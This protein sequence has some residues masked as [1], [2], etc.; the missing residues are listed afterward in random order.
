[1]YNSFLRKIVQA[2]LKHGFRPQPHVW[3]DH[4][5]KFCHPLVILAIDKFGHEPFLS[6][7]EGYDDYTLRRYIIDSIFKKNSLWTYG[8]VHAYDKHKPNTWKDNESYISGYIVG[9]K[10]RQELK[11]IFY[12]KE[13]LACPNI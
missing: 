3:M 1:M 10:I 7:G 2:Y 13:V 5:R 9:H 11:T 4:K 8:F 12:K 6:L